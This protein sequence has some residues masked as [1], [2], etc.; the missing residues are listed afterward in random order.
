MELVV[1]VGVI[2]VLALLI[3]LN[4][5]GQLD[6]AHD[7]RRKADL[8]K[9][10]IALE[11]YA[12]DHVCYPPEEDVVCGSNALVPYLDVV[13]CDP[14]SGTQSYDY[15]QLDCRKFAVFAKLAKDNDPII[16]EMDCTVGCGPDFAYNYYIKSNDAIPGEDFETVESGDLDGFVPIQP[17]CGSVSKY[18]MPNICSTCCP[19]FEY[20]CH[21]SGKWCV[22]DAVCAAKQ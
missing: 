7:G 5:G 3:L 9:L 20:K 17:I 10:K 6:K 19:G 12:S 8:D 14:S 15:E 22:P 13:P 2:L 16:G 21:S 18:C 4:Y 1:V 11:N